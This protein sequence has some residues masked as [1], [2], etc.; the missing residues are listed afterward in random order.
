MA[1]FFSN[2]LLRSQAAA[3]GMILQ[4]RLPA[5]FEP[6]AGA[7]EF[8]TPPARVEPEERITTVKQTPTPAASPSPEPPPAAQATGR[9]QTA[10]PPGPDRS[11]P[12]AVSN[13]TNPLLLE[14]RPAPA[15]AGETPAPA[16]VSIRLQRETVFS[17][18]PAPKTEPLPAPVENGSTPRAGNSPENAPRA[19]GRVLKA[20]DE[21]PPPEP[22]SRI[23]PPPEAPIFPK[24]E[25]I[26]PAATA[27]FQP[28]SQTVFTPQP[29]PAPRR[30]TEPTPPSS[31]TVVQVHIGRIDVRAAPPPAAPQP[32]QTPR[33]RPN[34]SLEEYLRQREEKR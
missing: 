21:T 3:S 9:P 13:A 19:T 34:L 8:H 7:E 10:P 29:G 4:P 26:K 23:Q 6:P 18:G 14:P 15:P 2:L 11:L 1:D 12:A 31:E 28:A 33:P 20:R 24:I 25:R 17:A 32:A 22:A 5:L 27:T 30:R 16:R